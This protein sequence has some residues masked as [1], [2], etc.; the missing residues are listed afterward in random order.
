MDSAFV[1]FHN[2]VPRMAVQEMDI[3]L[4]CPESWFQANS[5]NDFVAAVQCEPG[6]GER[7]LLFGE[8]LRRLCT[9]GSTNDATFLLGA[10]KLN[11]FAI[12]TCKFK[13]FSMHL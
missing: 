6:L 10:S 13:A 9:S 7:S 8:C 11:L 1:I 4:P 12:A 3:N 2:S 5:S